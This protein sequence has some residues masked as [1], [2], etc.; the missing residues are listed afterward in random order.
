VTPLC[1]AAGGTPA[2]NSAS[3]QTSPVIP[4]INQRFGAARR[5]IAVLKCMSRDPDEMSFDLG[6]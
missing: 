4:A 1:A 2:K 3:A 5:D 6:Q